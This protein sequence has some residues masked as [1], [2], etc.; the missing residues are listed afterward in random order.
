MAAVPLLPFAAAVSDGLLLRKLIDKG[1]STA[2]LLSQLSLSL[3][4]WP[5]RSS[6][7]VGVRTCV[8]SSS[9]FWIKSCGYSTSTLGVYVIQSKASGWPAAVEPPL[10]SEKIT[11]STDAAA[12]SGSNQQRSET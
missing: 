12:A 10:Y 8:S 9:S 11:E 2:R 4:L 3:A 1:L 5:L 6:T 7:G